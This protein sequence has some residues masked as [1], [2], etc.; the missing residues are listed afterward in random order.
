MISKNK[1]NVRSKSKKSVKHNSHSPEIYQLER[2]YRKFYP[3]IKL[4]NFF[5]HSYPNIQEGLHFGFI[6]PGTR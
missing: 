6:C 2:K 1:K 5:T 4:Q 3:E